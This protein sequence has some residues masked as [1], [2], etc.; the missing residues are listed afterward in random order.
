MQQTQG[1]M[2]V[3]LRI[4]GTQSTKPRAILA[5]NKQLYEWFSPSVGPSVCPSVTPF[6]SCSH[7]RIITK[8]SGVITTDRS[9][10]NA[11]FQGQRSKVKV[12]EA[13]TQF[14]RFRTVTQFALT[15]GDV[16]LHNAWC[17]LREVPYHF[18]CQPPNFKDTRLKKIKVTWDKKIPDFDPNWAFPDCNS[19]LNWHMALKWCT[20]PEAS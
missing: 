19:S 2:K 17:C 3:F 8:F 16:T 13:Q 6:S 1:Y 15:C 14:S 5:A 18:Q 4:T 7:H 12:T 9:E 20:K 11:K 10:V